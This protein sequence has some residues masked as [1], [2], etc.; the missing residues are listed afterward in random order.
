M[1]MSNTKGR[2]LLHDAIKADIPH[3]AVYLLCRRWGLSIDR[4][5]D[6]AAEAS[7]EA[8]RRSLEMRFETMRHY[9]HWL[10]RVAHNWI[11]SELRRQN[12]TR[13]LR[14][15]ELLAPEL[16]SEEITWEMVSQALHRL[17]QDHQILIRM[18]YWEGCTL[19]DVAERL[20]GN[21][22]GSA[23]SK[24]LK[25]RKQRIHALALLRSYIYMK[26]GEESL[27]Y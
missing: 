21:E 13:P 26:S 5:F 3:A 8:Q 14:E 19:D 1:Y 15:S 25:I 4:A 9:Q 11:V 22:L 23:N 27:L 7:S 10:F 17:S 6:L 12:R 18:I 24:R 16:E 20:L 2:D